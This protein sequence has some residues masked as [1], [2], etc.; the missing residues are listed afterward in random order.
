MAFK[1]DIYNE[2]TKK[3]KGLVLVEEE[4]ES[5]WLGSIL[6]VRHII[7]NKITYGKICVFSY[8]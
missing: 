4:M 8:Y 2:D 1:S 6:Q 5:F 7:Q 3:F